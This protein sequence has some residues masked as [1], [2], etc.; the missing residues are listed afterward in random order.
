MLEDWLETWANRNLMKFKGKCQ[1][2]P[3]GQG[4]LMLQG[5]CEGLAGTQ[6]CTEGVESGGQVEQESARSLATKSAATYWSVLAQVEPAG[7]SSPFNSCETTPRIL[8]QFW[9]SPVQEIY[10]YEGVKTESHQDMVEYKAYKGLR[11]FLVQP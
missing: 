10:C 8:C 4:K 11:E 1:A 6:L 9:G 3:L 7:H 5:S 2:S